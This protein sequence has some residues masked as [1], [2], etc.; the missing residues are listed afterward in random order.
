MYLAPLLRW[1]RLHAPLSPPQ[2]SG[3]EGE[4]SKAT[5]GLRRLAV[6]HP[7]NYSPHELPAAH[8]VRRI[9]LPTCEGTDQLTQ[10]DTSQDRLHDHATF[11]SHTCHVI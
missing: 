1:S 8:F 9:K 6:D 5:E 2:T 4:T 3:K 7:S 10:L 11:R